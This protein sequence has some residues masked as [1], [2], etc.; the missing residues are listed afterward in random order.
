MMDENRDSILKEAFGY[1]NAL[2]TYAYSL[3]RDHA[4]AEDAVQSAYV[5][6]SGRHDSIT[7]GSILAW[8]RGAVRLE[9]LQTIRKTGREMSTGD[10]FLLDAVAD[11]FEQVQT[12]DREAMR[13]ERLHHLRECFDKLPQRSRDLV[14]GRYLDGEKLAELSER[15]GMKADAVRKSLYRIRQL[16]REC[17]ERKPL[18]AP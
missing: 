14:G 7:G 1:H 16:L 8:C 17:L 13:S 9:A 2:V 6:L 3:L 15:F 10:T 11:T 18:S 12:P 4:L 5:A